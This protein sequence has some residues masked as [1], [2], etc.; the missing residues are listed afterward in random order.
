MQ[1]ANVALWTRLVPVRPECAVRDFWIAR[2]RDIDPSAQLR[3]N[4]GVLVPDRPARRFIPG[5][6]SRSGGCRLAPALGLKQG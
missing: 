4:P 3:L 6:A 1:H 2:S 5:Y